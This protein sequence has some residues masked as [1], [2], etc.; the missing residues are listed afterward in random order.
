MVDERVGVV[1][2][3][4]VR[5]RDSKFFSLLETLLLQLPPLQAAGLPSSPSRRAEKE[6]EEALPL[7]VGQEARV[8]VVG[9]G[10]VRWRL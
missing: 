4:V 1:G 7:V 9:C 10:V 5:W 2:C 8:G 3:G 6:E